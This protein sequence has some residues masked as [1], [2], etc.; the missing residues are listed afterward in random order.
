MLLREACCETGCNAS[1][2]EA[3]PTD[4]ARVEVHGDEL[5]GRGLVGAGLLQLSVKHAVAR[6]DG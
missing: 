6:V 1:E 4:R 5:K 3:T 2:V